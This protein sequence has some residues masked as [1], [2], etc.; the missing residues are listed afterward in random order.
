M[1]KVIIILGILFIPYISFAA[2]SI[3][4]VSGTFIHSKIV[5]I[6]GSSFGT[7]SPAK[8]LVWIDF[9]GGSLSANSSLSASPDSYSAE[10]ITLASNTNPHSRSTY[11]AYGVN[12]VNGVKTSSRLGGLLGGASK[13]FFFAR[14]KSEPGF[15]SSISNT[16]YIWLWPESSEDTIDTRITYANYSNPHD[17]NWPS[18]G[19]AVQWTFGT[20]GGTATWKDSTCDK[21]QWC[22]SEFQDSKG[23]IDVANGTLKYWLNGARRVNQSNV[24][25]RTTKY[26]AMYKRI[27]YATYYAISVPGTNPP[28]N[29]KYY[30]DDMYIDSTWARVMIGNAPTFDACTHREPLIPTAWS[31]SSI[32]AYFN[33]GSFPNGQPVYVFVVDADGNAS[34]G[35]AITIGGAAESS[36]NLMPSPPAKLSIN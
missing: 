11:S 36:S 2:P 7:K 22:I 30:F 26:P 25:N 13:V 29:G 33:Q 24:M 28:N 23:D 21:G 10:N 15:F 27:E 20:P 14:Q 6:T 34:P 5:T 31:S 19:F 32:T 9:E 8:P 18:S 1:R 12:F 4:N 3:S 16:K 35:K 17:P